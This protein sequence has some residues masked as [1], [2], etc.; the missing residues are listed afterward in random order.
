M[1]TPATCP[2]G[3]SRY[4]QQYPIRVCHE[5]PAVAL[6]QTASGAPAD[7]MFGPATRQ[8]VRVF[9]QMNGL[10]ADGLVG[11]MTWAAMFPSGAPGVD[12]DRDGTVE[13]W[14]VSRS[15]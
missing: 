1:T 10:N 11:P 5:G 7:G 3:Y 12:A 14:E 8:S 6:I 13:P 15:R 9:Q 4:P 2:N